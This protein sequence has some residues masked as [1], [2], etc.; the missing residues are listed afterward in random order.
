MVELVANLS[1][2]KDTWGHVNRLIESGKWDKVY[3][4]TNEF[5]KENFN[6]KDN[7]EFLIIDSNQ[8]LCELRDFLYKELK[9]KVKSSEIGLNLV[10]GSG[11]EHMALLSAVLKL[12]VGIQLVAMTKGGSTVL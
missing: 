5:G 4:I 3:L 9:E 8:G 12:G 10:S 7:V 2:G 6:K 1:T 11:K